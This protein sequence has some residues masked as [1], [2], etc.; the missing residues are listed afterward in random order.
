MFSAY[1][2]T[3]S[4]QAEAHAQFRAQATNGEL[5]NEVARDSAFEAVLKEEMRALRAGFQLRV[6]RLQEELSRAKVGPISEFNSINSETVPSFS[7]LR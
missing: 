7:S 5:N 1:G 2:A 4:C 6:A 3:S